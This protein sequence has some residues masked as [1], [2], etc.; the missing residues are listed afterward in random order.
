MREKVIQAIKERRLL[1]LQYERGR[2]LTVAPQV[3]GQTM[4]GYLALFCWHA[5]P[6]VEAETPWRLLDLARITSVRP[7]EQHFGPLPS[8]RGLPGREFQAIEAVI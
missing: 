1:S 6:A 5:E 7:L 2:R 3:L 4:T 8:S